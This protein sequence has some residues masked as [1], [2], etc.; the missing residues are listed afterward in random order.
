MSYFNL[1]DRSIISM[2]ILEKSRRCFLKWAKFLNKLQLQSWS[3]LSGSNRNRFE[4]CRARSIKVTI[5]YK[6]YLIRSA[7]L[8]NIPKVRKKS[9]SY[10]WENRVAS[11]LSGRIDSAFEG[12]TSMPPRSQSNAS[13]GNSTRR[14]DHIPRLRMIKFILRIF[15]NCYYFSD[16]LWFHGLFTF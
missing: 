12:S 7:S 3:Q 1:K 5:K 15:I 14:Q 4:S 8:S 11:S 13:S 6:A 16:S 10:Y 9:L 2:L